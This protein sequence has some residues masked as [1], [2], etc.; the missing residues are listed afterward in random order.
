MS[1]SKHFVLKGRKKNMKKIDQ[2]VNLYP[3]SKTLR[4]K[5]IPVG[6]TQENIDT[7]RLIEED[8]DRGEKYKKAKKIID[9]YHRFFIDRVLHD[10]KIAGIDDYICLFNKHN[11]TDAEI[12]ELKAIE[13]NLR[14]Q[15]SELFKKDPEY[16]EL[17]G[18]GLIK[19]VLPKWLDNDEEKSIIE[20]F[21]GFKTAFQGFNQNR[22][23]MYSAE[24]KST[25]IAYRCINDNLPKF[26][27][28]MNCFAKIRGSLGEDTL[29]K[30]QKE[31]V[32]EPYKI[33][34][35][36][37]SDFFE[38]VLTNK[39]IEFYNSLIGGFVK[40]SGE[41]VQGL[42]EFINLY[43]QQ[44]SKRDNTQKLP[45][46]KPLYKQVLAERESYS[47]YEEGYK[48]TEELLEDL[49]KTSGKGSDVIKAVEDLKALFDN[50]SNYNM[51]GIYVKN[52]VAITDLSNNVAGNWAVFRTNWNKRYDSRNYS[53]KIK[54]FEKYEE[55]RRKDYNR[56]ESFS[57]Q[58]ISDNLITEEAV[59]TTSD[60]QD[61]YKNSV[62]ELT[63]KIGT[64]LSSVSDLNMRRT[65]SLKA[66][67][68]QIIK[69]YLDLLKQ[70]EN[71]VKP[72][73]GSERE[74]ERDEVFYGELSQP[75]LRLQ[76]IDALYNRV[77]NY[78]TKKPYS[79]DK[80]KLYFQNPQLLGGWDRSKVE[81]YRSTLLRKDGK[82]YVAVIDKS[83]SRA[84]ASLGEYKN[85][86]AYEVLDYK[87]IPGASKQL[88]HI[89]FSGKGIEEYCPSKEVASIYVKKTFLKS[90]S[91]FN[92]TNCH[93][94]IDY[95]KSCIE[96]S[97]LNDAFGFHF[98]ETNSYN[99]ISGFFHEV[100]NQGYKLSFYKVN[101]ESIDALVEQGKI[102]LF[103]L[104]NKDFSKYS[105]GTE[106]LHTIIFRQIFNEEN[107]GAIK[108]CG[109]AEF[110]FRKA[111]I[112]PEK[113]VVHKANQAVKNKNP[114]NPKKESVF[115]HD[116]IKDKRY[117][118]DQ[119]EIHIP[120]TLNRTAGGVQKLNE[121]VRM[122][123]KM[124]ANPY[125]VG[126]DRGE[127]NLLYIC[128][129][130][131]K[132]NIV[133]QY[134]LNEIVNEYKGV[135]IRTN[136][137]ELLANKEEE[138]LKARQEWTSIENIKE[139]KEGYISQVIN[140]IC[141]LVFKYDAVIAMEDLNSGFKNSRVK[142]EKQVYQKFEKALI[143]KFNYMS[144]KHIEIGENGSV[145]RGYQ[146]AN[147][148]KS[149]NS[150]GTQNGFIFYIP[151]WLTS[152]I[153]PVTG[154]VDLLKPKYTSINDSK[155][156]IQL[157]D[158]IKYSKSEDMFE[159]HIDYSKF[160]RTDA[161][162]KKKWIVYSNGKRIKTYRNPE[163][164]NEYDN[165][166]IC[167]TDEFKSLL[168]KY[169]IAYDKDDLREA[170]CELNVK[171][172]YENFLGLLRLTL[173]LRNS[174]TGRTDIDYLISPVRDKNGV[175][176]CSDDCAENLP[177][178]ADANGAYNIARKV[179]W[180]IEKFKEADPN[181]LGKVKIAISNK[182]WLEFAQTREK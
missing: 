172:F 126:I 73:W 175:F 7:K 52:G 80:V 92:V 31:H 62:E 122:A 34:D 27:S 81:A 117:T 154:F 46:L 54:D 157:F 169:G 24:E 67:D 41:K 2:F 22:E 107:G 170:I 58:D 51:N 33:D 1:S 57:M 118:V 95:Y 13:A 148:F 163:K 159:F 71:L 50:I 162:Y 69:E 147:P 63:E 113:M 19:V 155:T 82:Y 111:S 131:G 93:K 48:S 88:P 91:D 79:Q 9:K 74:D 59:F 173:Q 97:D 47:F 36:F 180:A 166:E 133:E 137:H 65:S 72:L 10:A 39:G 144:N 37:S 78:V 130:D 116:L 179:L 145:T 96:R 127:R 6:K 35:L 75:F 21:I 178:N 83:D 101:A 29:A 138:R 161:S 149:F 129:I 151:A 61:Y 123:L 4:F 11:K 3:V 40:E 152:K 136:Y 20:S 100:D 84:L 146:I 55:K 120:V 132:G 76:E 12:E 140:K 16:K 64:S 18:E 168:A 110:F 119:Y 134:S 109:G 28:N 153:D 77:R 158:A 85:G 177:Q 164:N 99:D 160:P 90:S 87:L 112:A 89:F 182:E 103:Q 102:Y 43:N 108:L 38:F 60:I 32:I 25:A 68:V 30:I 106:N 141:E 171:E 8:V 42:N 121:S 86:P 165:E 70:L 156:F 23:N 114:L 104:Y 167:L 142:V 181:E 135:Q 125:I 26:I 176:Y 174:V 17:F 45:L 66:E 94:I 98:S 49:M 139:L 44:L 15:I 105:H 124:D 150:M 56:I 14:K 128:V 143:D 53:A 5:A 115:P